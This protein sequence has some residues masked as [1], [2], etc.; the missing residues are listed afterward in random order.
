M[1]Y[2]ITYGKYSRHPYGDYY[3]SKEEAEKARQDCIAQ[4][5]KSADE[6]LQREIERHEERINTI[7]REFKIKESKF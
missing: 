3:N 5:I 6:R 2:F 7:P 4:H 1:K